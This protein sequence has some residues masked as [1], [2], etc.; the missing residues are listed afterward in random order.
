M[1]Q[2]LENI[3]HDIK[4]VIIIREDLKNFNISV[5]KMAVQV[6]HGAVEGFRLVLR[7]NPK[8]A[9]AWIHQGQKKI[10]LRVPTLAKLIEKYRIADDLNI[11]AS[12]IVDAGLT[13]LPPNTPTVL[14]LGPWY[15]DIIDKVSGNLPLL[16]YW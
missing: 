13:E 7:T 15:A 14:V 16:K 4:Q 12:I 6:A 3:N 9:R 11:P 10:L 5:G 1:S 8:I 2:L